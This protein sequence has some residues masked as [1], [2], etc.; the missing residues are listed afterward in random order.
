MHIFHYP[1]PR[2][3]IVRQKEALLRSSSRRPSVPCLPH[4]SK[5][6]I[7]PHAARNP[8]L[9]LHARESPVKPRHCAVAAALLLLLLPLPLLAALCVLF[10]LGYSGRPHSRRLTCRRRPNRVTGMIFRSVSQAGDLQRPRGSNSGPPPRGSPPRFETVC[11]GLG[12][13]PSYPQGSSAPFAALL[14]SQ[15]CT[16][17]LLEFP[18]NQIADQ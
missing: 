11:P 15:L 16:N 9:G 17:L 18:V 3:A 12:L 8:K 5:P 2:L 1:Y 6:L 10:R 13:G 7:I 14:G 4:G